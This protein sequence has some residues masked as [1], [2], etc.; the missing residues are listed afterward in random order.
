MTIYFWKYQNC[1]SWPWPFFNHDH[2]FWTEEVG[3]SYSHVNPCHNILPSVPK[4]LTLRP[5]PLPLTYM[6]KTN[7]TSKAGDHNSLNLLVC[8]CT[9]LMSVKLLL[10]RALTYFFILSGFQACK[11]FQRCLRKRRVH[12]LLTPVG[13]AYARTF[14]NH[15]NKL[16][17]THFLS[18]SEITK[19]AFCDFIIKNK[20]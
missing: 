16:K 5:W 4:S 19:F 12:V 15:L 17:G 9:C 11:M 13:S 3:R 10:G 18:R 1:R 7:K 14:C 6:I 2:N 20:I 8:F